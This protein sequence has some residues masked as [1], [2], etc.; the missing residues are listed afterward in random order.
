VEGFALEV[1]FKEYLDSML[2]KQID[3]A[4]DHM[5]VNQEVKID[6]KKLDRTSDS[7][8]K[9]FG[10][11]DNKI[12]KKELRKIRDYRMN[13]MVQRGEMQTIVDGYLY[14]LALRQGKWIGGI[15]DVTDQMQLR[16]E[17]GADL[18]AEEV[19][20]PEAEMKR[21]LDQ[22]VRIYLEQDLGTLSQMINGERSKWKDQIL[23]RRNI[24]MARRMDSLSHLRTMFFAIGAA[25]LPGDSG[26][27]TLLRSKGFSVEPIFSSQKIAAEIYAKQLNQ[28]A[29]KRLEDEDKLY[30]IEMPGEP[31]SKSMLG[32]AFKMKMFFDLTT[33]TLYMTGHTI[34]KMD[35]KEE[36][37]QMFESIAGRM[38]VGKGKIRKKN[39]DNGNVKGIEGSFE[40]EQGA[41]KVQILQK[42]NNLFTLLVGSNKKTNLANSDIDKFFNSFVA[43]DI[44][45][46]KT[47]WSQFKVEEKAYSVMMPGTPKKNNVIDRQAE[48]T[49]WRFETYDY[50]DNDKGLYYL[51]QVRDMQD[52]YYLQSDSA[53]IATYKA[54]LETK[55]EE[56]RRA[57]KAEYKGFPAYYID[58]YSPKKN[59]VFRVFYVIRGNRVY[60]LVAGGHSSVD[61]SDIDI[62]FNSLVLDDYKPSE[63]KTRYSK[64]FSTTAPG[65]IRIIEKEPTDSTVQAEET[66]TTFSENFAVFNNNESVSYVIFKSQFP[67]FYWTSND[68][69]YLTSK[70]ESYLTNEDSII[71]KDFVSNG[72]LKAIEFIIQSKGNH[73]FKK[74]RVFVNGDTLY[75]LLSYIPKQYIDRSGHQKFYSDFR[76]SHEVQPT[77]YT[78]K[79]SEL[80]QALESKDSIEFT[81]AIQ[82]LY[83]SKFGKEDLPLLHK[84]LIGNYVRMSSDSVQ[85]N[86]KFIHVLGDLG[87]STTLKFI[88]SKYS[89]ISSEKEELKYK[90]LN[91][92]AQIKTR[93]SYLLLKK[94]LL[95]DLPKKDNTGA[96]GYSLSDSLQLTQ[97]LF[98]EVLTLLKDSDF[99]EVLIPVV[100]ELLDSSLLEMKDIIPYRQVVLEQAKKYLK[101]INSEEDSWYQYLTWIAFTGRFND[102]ISN[103]LLQDYLKKPVLGIKKEAVVALLKNKQGINK[104]EIEKLAADRDYRIDIYDDLLKL[105]RMDLFPGRYLNQKAISESE[106][107]WAGSEDAEVSDIVFLEERTAEFMGKKQKFYLYKLSYKYDDTI[108]SYLGIAGPY[109]PSSKTIVRN[110]AATGI[111]WD[112]Q[113]D[114]KQISSQFKAHLQSW[115]EFLKENESG[116]EGIK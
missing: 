90:L 46:R 106:V 51:M 101:L 59:A 31:L 39:I 24:K 64:G 7:I 10:I 14:G 43:N 40:V 11:K 23:T 103:Q 113:Y 75:T 74:V 81:R 18:D 80:I 28:L 114:N 52:G 35:S 54:D 45:S 15:E 29:W 32:E 68:S 5:L 104:L 66:E 110:S 105:E 36:A 55:F 96:L 9:Q 56:I 76:V 93:E 95:E 112:A 83:D 4:Q 116:T 102:E 6:R 67:K 70:M 25:H 79:A 42:G 94:L 89:T 41:Y 71:K 99:A 17:M 38:G 19:L 97:I 21:S 98:P 63:W 69:S 13:K 91:V 49:G 87:D 86:E 53:Y 16:D 111:Y 82:A 8:L 108:E 62:F 85:I 12:T 2:G 20:M 1:D 61:L 57:E 88:A 30:S 37:N 48:G 72:K 47:S 77:I 65:E 34:G 73:N 109:L 60:S 27:I 33:M 50:L 84:A 92:L 115:E 44:T 3:E 26:V 100:S 78:T 58:A 22:M 107:Q